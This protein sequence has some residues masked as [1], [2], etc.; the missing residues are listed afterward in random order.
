MKTFRII[1]VED[2][3]LN[4]QGFYFVENENQYIIM[5]EFYTPEFLCPKIK[6]KAILE[7]TDG[8]IKIPENF[9]S[10]IVM[11]LKEGQIIQAIKLYRQLTGR[12]LK[13]AKNYCDKIREEL[14]I[15][16]FNTE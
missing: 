6:I 12:G 3:V 13:E 1:F 15:Y 16:P 11:L 9:N 5:N 7:L 8:D 14:K 10:E 2:F 4:I